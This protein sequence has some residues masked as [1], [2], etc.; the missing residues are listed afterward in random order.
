MKCDGVN[1]RTGAECS[2]HGKYAAL[3]EPEDEEI[4]F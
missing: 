3:S 2:A 4:L 1:L